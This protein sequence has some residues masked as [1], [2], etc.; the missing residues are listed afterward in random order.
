MNTVSSSFPPLMTGCQ[1]FKDRASDIQPL[2]MDAPMALLTAALHGSA[3]A[4]L[5]ALY[6][7]VTR[8]RDA[9]TATETGAMVK[10]EQHPGACLQEH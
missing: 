4:G 7:T 6:T 3:N 10:R 2:R 9:A 1:T 8:R 5:Q